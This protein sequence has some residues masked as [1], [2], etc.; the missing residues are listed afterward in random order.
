MNISK[1]FQRANEGE[2]FSFKTLNDDIIKNM[3]IDNK[4]IYAEGQF[5]RAFLALFDGKLWI[6]KIPKIKQTVDANYYNMNIEIRK[7]AQKC[8]SEFNK[9]NFSKKIKF[10]NIKIIEFT[11]TLLI[12]NVERFREID[13]NTYQ[14]YATMEPFIMGKYEK[15]N[16][17]Y[18]YVN[19]KTDEIFQAFSHFTYYYLETDKLVVDLQGY[20]NGYT[21]AILTDPAIHSSDQKYA[22]CDLKWDGFSKFF[23]THICRDYCKK[24]MIDRYI[25]IQQMK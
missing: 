1:L 16:S 25:Y 13:I 18:G 17:N 4:N 20:D 19:K 15:F 6:I 23:K 8:A 24:M 10:V 5:N 2:I 7:I 9:Y 11:N 22:E 14:K 3:K 21:T 12:G